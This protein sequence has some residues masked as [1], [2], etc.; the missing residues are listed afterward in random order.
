[1][2]LTNH[3]KKPASKENEKSEKDK[4]CRNTVINLNKR[5]S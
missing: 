5:K 2:K 3:S 4:T 1:M